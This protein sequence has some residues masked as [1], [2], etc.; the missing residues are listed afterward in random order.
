MSSIV[1]LCS[2]AGFGA[3]EAFDVVEP[4]CSGA[5][6]SNMQLY[7][8]LLCWIMACEI[9]ALKGVAPIFC[10]FWMLSILSLGDKFT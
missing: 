8:S 9:D 3:W 2:S 4:L 5:H 10:L 1:T 6:Y 7:L